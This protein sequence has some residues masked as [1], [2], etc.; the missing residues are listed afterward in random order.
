MR[1]AASPISP[2]STRATSRAELRQPIGNR[3]FGCDDC[4][5]VCPWN[6]FAAAA[7]E[8][9]L[10]VREEA[11]S[12]PL[13]ELLALDDAALPRPLRRHAGEAHGARPRRAQRPDRRRQLGRCRACIPAVER[14]SP[15]PRRWCG[16]WR[17]GRSRRSAAQRPTQRLGTPHAG[18]MLPAR[19]IRPC[20]RSGDLGLLGRT[21]D[22]AL[23][24]RIRL[25]GGGA[26]AQAEP[27]R[28]A[29]SPARAPTR[30]RRR[31]P[32][33]RW[34][35]TGATVPRPRCAA[36]SPAPRTCSSA[37]R[38]ILRATRC[39]ATSPPTSPRSRTSPG[40]ATSPPSASTATPGAPGWTRRARS[41]R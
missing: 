37:S 29:R 27:A 38:P 41:A 12:P 15:T 26:G 24:L 11:R 34:P 33:R 19:P 17:C 5:A 7:R 9:R 4:L 32:A 13:A 6:K 8:T 16:R 30:R 20:G 40:S 3:V 31:R 10:A 39:C 14:L 21:A 18:A 1:G 2:S 23:L 28:S 35:P 36:C 25:F 22:A